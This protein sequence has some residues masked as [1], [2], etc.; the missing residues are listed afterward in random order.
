MC[1]ERYEVQAPLVP[2]DD[3]LPSPDELTDLFI[4]H[5]WRRFVGG[6]LV[7]FSDQ[8][9]FVGSDAEIQQARAWLDALILDFYTPDFPGVDMAYLGALVT[10]TTGINATNAGVLVPFEFNSGSGAHDVGGFWDIAEPYYLTVPV[11]GAGYY[12]VYAYGFSYAAASVP[13]M[14]IHKGISGVL[15]SNHPDEIKAVSLA[16]STTLFLDDGE[17]CTLEIRTN[18]VNRTFAPIPLNPYAAT[19][20]MYRVGIAL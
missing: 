10:R 18:G 11:G 7:N 12:R 4:N 20:G 15:V 2:H 16:C 6:L 14:R 8:V 13:I 19:L 5:I 1:A 9:D 17:F 3:I